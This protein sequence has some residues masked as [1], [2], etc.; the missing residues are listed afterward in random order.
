MLGS[1]EEIPQIIIVLDAAWEQR[2]QVYWRGCPRWCST[3]E[4]AIFIGCLRLHRHKKGSQRSGTYD[5]HT[6]K[7]T[8]A[9]AQTYT[10]KHKRHPDDCKLSH[11]NDQLEILDKECFTFKQEDRNF[12]VT[13]ITYPPQPMYILIRPY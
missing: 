4:E 3:G 7:R 11:I 2:C 6:R 1:P 13:H 12:E 8:H 5:K 9:C 10:Y